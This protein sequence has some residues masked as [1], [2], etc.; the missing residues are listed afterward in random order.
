MNDFIDLIKKLKWLFF[1][2]FIA[3][4]IF[5]FASPEVQKER[6][7][8]VS[9]QSENEFPETE[10]EWIQKKQ[11]AEIGL[12]CN[13]FIFNEE[14]A[15]IYILLTLEDKKLMNYPEYKYITE[16]TFKASEEI[17]LELETRTKTRIDVSV[18]EIKIGIYKNLFQKSKL[19]SR[20]YELIINRTDLSALMIDRI[21]GGIK[22]DFDLIPDLRGQCIKIPKENIYNMV[23]KNNKN[24]VDDNIL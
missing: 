21:T 14:E 3:F 4:L 8:F 9:Q 11:D 7:E 6:D 23:S 22:A 12:L 16:K 19:G 18:E 24:I 2:G 15:A 20:Y 10:E 17:L 5:Y 13:G 1:A